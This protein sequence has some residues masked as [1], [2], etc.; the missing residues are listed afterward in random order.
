MAWPTG[1]LVFNPLDV[2]CGLE[3]SQE[4]KLNGKTGAR[5]HVLET[6]NEYAIGVR[7]KL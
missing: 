6:I 4:R 7:N 3:W 2:F 1:S 5:C